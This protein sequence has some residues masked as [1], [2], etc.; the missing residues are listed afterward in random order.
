M[1]CYHCGL[2]IPNGADYPVEI[3]G[4]TREMCCTGCQA[5]AEAIV[6]NDLT[7]FYRFRTEIG[8]NPEDLVPKALRELEIYDLPELQQSFVRNEGEHIREASLILEGIVCAACVWLNEHHVRQLG[9][10]LDFRINYS[11]HRATLKWDNSQLR[12]SDILASIQA[13]GYHAHPFDPNR[14]DDLQKKEK[15]A[16]LRRIAVAGL[17]MMQVMMVAIALYIGVA[18]DMGEGM[19]NFLRWI[20]FVMTVPVVLYS[21]RIFFSSAWRD[22]R[23][24]RF[25]MD[26]PVSLAIGIAFSASVWATFTGTG[27]VYFDS[28]TMFTFFLLTGRYL[29]MSARH[30]AGQVAD[31]LVRLLPAT[32]TRLIGSDSETVAVSQLEVND[33]VLVKAGEVVPADGRVIDGQSSINE[34]LLT[35]ESVPCHKQVG[36]ELVGGT[37]NV[38]SPLTMRIEKLGDSTVLASIIRLLERAQAEKPELARLAEKVASRFVPIILVI[39]VAVFFYWYQARPD[40][41]FWIALSVLVVTCPCAFSLATPAALT[42]ATGLL[43][44]HGV[45]TT[46][47]HAL[48]TL[49]RV[50]HVIFDKTGTLTQ[51]QLAVVKTHVFGSESQ[52]YYQQLAAGLERTSEHPIAQAI[53]KLSDQ[54]FVLEG[55]QV[56]AGKGVIGRY[57]DQAFRIGT[58]SFIQAGFANKSDLPLLDTNRSTIYL[59][60]EQGVLAAFELMD[61]LRPEAKK[62]VAELQQKGIKVSLLSGD[63]QHVVT[64]VAQELA[65]PNA[66]GEQLP[67][68]KLAY[69]KQQQAQGDVVVMVGDGVNDA[70]VLA[71]AQVSIA[72][73]EGSQLAQASADMVLLSESLQQLPFSIQTAKRM[74][75]IIKQNF[76][77]TIAYNTVAIPIAALGFI[78]P[79]MAAIGM[80]ASSLI[81]VLNALRLRH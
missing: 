41:A 37:V 70:P 24:G 3:D 51:G 11:T 31:E 48:E 40:E 57:Q 50:N 65:I 54:P 47:G 74:Q 69:V 80:S 23:R 27:E 29:E 10:V 16:A 44:S 58:A 76:A 52:A 32:A 64:A 36:D 1:S 43:T 33:L 42:A 77:W 61:Q 66:L 49:A 78:A 5:V 7:D 25:G 39:A 17:G 15:S 12:L 45:L 71:G 55:I 8:S 59:G 14:L 13:I 2:P 35:G 81:V 62:M 73:G 34:S 6:K 60:N 75:R 18:S 56:E 28:V 53:L 20:S 79:W 63:Q 68:D 67:D 9:G 46:R 19:Q 22:L 26:V 72:M 4:E 30:K 38:D 21:S